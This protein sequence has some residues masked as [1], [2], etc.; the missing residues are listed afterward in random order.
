MSLAVH[1]LL[2]SGVRLSFTFYNA[3]LIKRIKLD[4]SEN[5]L[6][7]SLQVYFGRVSTHFRIRPPSWIQ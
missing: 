1:A 2:K 7:I 4:G 3:L 6:L 5:S